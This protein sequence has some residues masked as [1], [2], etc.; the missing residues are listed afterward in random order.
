MPQQELDLLQVTAGL[1]AQLPACAAKII[2]TKSLD[3]ISFA[4]SVTTD[5]I[6]QSR[7]ERS[8]VYHNKWALVHFW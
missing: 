5:Q 8:V 3:P 6:A 7:E 4:D 2:G 1:A